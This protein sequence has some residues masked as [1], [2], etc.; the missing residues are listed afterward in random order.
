MLT[1]NQ[2]GLKKVGVFKAGWGK[3][4]EGQ[5]KL[6]A[7][8][9]SKDE[10][11]YL[12]HRL[13]DLHHSFKIHPHLQDKKAK[14]LIAYDILTIRNTLKSPRIIKQIREYSEVELWDGTIDQRVLIRSSKKERVY[15]KDKGYLIC[16]LL[17][18]VSLSRSEIITAYY[19]HK[20]HTYY[21]NNDRYDD[22][23]R[24]I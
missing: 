11:T 19:S 17:F 5:R 2:T 21:K 12:T 24:I 16:N 10:K 8:Q 6:H 15:I 18:V 4:A 1:Q 3:N 9:M 14:G 13:N 20:N 23:L 22:T 7:E